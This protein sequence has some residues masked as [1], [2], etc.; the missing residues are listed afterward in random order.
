MTNYSTKTPVRSAHHDLHENSPKENYQIYKKW[1]KLFDRNVFLSLGE[2]CLSDNI[3]DRNGLKSFSSP[4]ASARSNIEYALLFEKEQYS[5]FLNPEYLRKELFHSQTAV[6]RNK[7]Y[8]ELCNR[9]DRSVTNGFEFTHHN[10]LDNHTLRDT[11]RR[12]YKRMLNLKKKHIVFL[13]H[14]RVCD[15]TDHNLLIDHL[16]QFAEIYRS[17]GNTVSIYLYVQKI[18]SSS[19]ERHVEYFCDRGINC[20]VFFTHNEWSGNDPDILWA[21]CDDDLLHV[22]IDHMKGVQAL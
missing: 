10:V 20:F 12:R 18:I 6:V 15:Q 9:Y 3:L 21:R 17:R 1:L 5:D 16:N 11:L 2:N 4:Y 8:V 13:Y 22:M 19:E 14:H 7:K